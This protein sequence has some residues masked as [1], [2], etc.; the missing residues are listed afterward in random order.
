[1]N[2]SP[3]PPFDFGHEAPDFNNGNSQILEQG[4]T[5]ELAVEAI[6]GARGNL[7]LASERTGFSHA[8]LT[9]AASRNM[10]QLQRELKTRTLIDAFSLLDIFKLQLQARAHELEAADVSKTYT[11]LI[12][13]L[14][15][16]TDDKTS[17]MN[18]NVQEF[19]WSQL[20][21]GVKNAVMVLKERD[22]L[23]AL[24]APTNSHG[25]PDDN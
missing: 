25:A 11:T 1:M 5:P 21:A 22:E 3:F 7:H 4:L 24:S 14:S 13:L 2:S 12:Q 17:N 18:I 16:L 19:I 23:A 6:V 15:T 10:A 9:S 8:E 20:P